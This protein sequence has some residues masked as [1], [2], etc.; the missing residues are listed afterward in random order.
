MPT[1]EAGVI[2]SKEQ[3]EAWLY[4]S[5]FLRIAHGRIDPDV[6]KLVAE[7]YHNSLLTPAI[8]RPVSGERTTAYSSRGRALRFSVEAG[9]RYTLLLSTDE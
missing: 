7:F 2:T 6:E 3:Y 4:L 9:R 1:Q 8:R 5:E